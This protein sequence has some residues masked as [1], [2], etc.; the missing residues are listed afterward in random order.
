MDGP[1]DPGH[2][3]TVL[4]G[5]SELLKD[6]PLSVHARYTRDEVLTAIGRSTLAKPFTHREGPLCH[7]PSR[8]NFLFI[9]LD[10]SEKYYSPTTRYR[11][12]A[13]SPDLF[14]WESQ[15]GTSTASPTGQRY[16]HH[17]EQGVNVMLLV[18]PANK[19][20]GRTM[21]FML[22]GPATIVSHA[23]ERPMSIVWRL[24]LPMPADL[25]KVA[26]VAAG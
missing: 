15:S 6:V 23:G 3:K 24:H 16:I 14:H 4:T 20:D 25:F 13:I 11:D 5:P 21:P 12:Y 17:V 9:T 7:E 18:R 26:E 10:K 19:Q 22:L 1:A 2:F 8:T